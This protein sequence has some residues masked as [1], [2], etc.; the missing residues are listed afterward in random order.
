[1][2]ADQ[3]PLASEI[4]EL[5]YGYWR[6][7]KKVA[8][9]AQEALFNKTRDSLP[10]RYDI[11]DAHEP[12]LWSFTLW[13]KNVTFNAVQLKPYYQQV[14][15][16]TIV[17]GGRNHSLESPILITETNTNPVSMFA[18]RNTTF[19]GKEIET[20]GDCLPGGDYVW[21]FSSLMLFT[22]C[23]L[24]LLVA[25]LLIVLH[26]DAY[27]Y[28]YADRYKLYVSPYRDVLDLAQ[29]LSTHF[30]AA[31]VAAM[32]AK[33]LDKAMQQDPAATGLDTVALHPPRA[34]RWR[35]SPD[36]KWPFASKGARTRPGMPDRVGTEAEESLMSIGLNAHGSD[37]EMGKL[38]AKAVTKQ[39]T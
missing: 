15:N 34:L 28:S 37:F 21:G 24:T 38:P 13:P 17:I 19:Y 30:G 39:F 5:W 12:P 14:L 10:A 4:P 23:M 8:Y 22:F 3:I 32:P 29:E 20:I 2:L 18:Y 25:I 27:Y 7:Y 6:S 35:Q 16:S 36:S 11:T 26:Y 31:E 1:M 9:N 33:E